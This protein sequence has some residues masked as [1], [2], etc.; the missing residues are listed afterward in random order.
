[1][2]V[3]DLFS[4]LGGWSSAFIAAGNDVTTVDIDTKFKPAIFSELLRER[5]ALVS[6]GLKSETL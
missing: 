1:M 6:E 4:G 2:R 3:L 5:F